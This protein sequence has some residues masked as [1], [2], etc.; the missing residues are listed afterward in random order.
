VKMR[1]PSLALCALYITSL[2][3]VTSVYDKTAHYRA[4]ASPRYVHGSAGF[5]GD[6]A[7]RCDVPCGSGCLI[8][9]WAFGGGGFQ[10]MRR[11]RSLRRVLFVPDGVSA[12]Q[13]SKKFPSMTI[14]PLPLL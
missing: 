8:H 14:I 1:I 9:A 11:R 5:R 4:R 2:K 12:N 13:R 10:K 3:P 7:D 6:A